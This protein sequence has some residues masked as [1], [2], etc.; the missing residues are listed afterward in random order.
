MVVTEG[1]KHYDRS[2]SNFANKHNETSII[3]SR[4]REGGG[5]NYVRHCSKH[6][7]LFAVQLPDAARTVMTLYFVLR[8]LEF[9]NTAT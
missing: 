4:G 6:C 3:E 7:V 1:S 5:T 2:G 8:P 9:Q